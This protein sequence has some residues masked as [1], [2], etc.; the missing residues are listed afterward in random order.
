[1]HKETSCSEEKFV[2]CREENKKR[3]GS[4]FEYTNK[5]RKGGGGRFVE[6]REDF[7]RKKCRKT[8]SSGE[9][10]IK[11]WRSL[12]TLKVGGNEIPERTFH[13]YGIL[14][15]KDR[16]GTIE[17]QVQAENRNKVMRE[18][19]PA[20]A[21]KHDSA[22]TPIQKRNKMY[23]T[24]LIVTSGRVVVCVGTRELGGVSAMS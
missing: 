20:W 1:M 4:K 23:K 10:R 3:E 9:N 15:A 24:L 18:A 19:A 17:K 12:G 22:I 7:E 14:C 5:K 8:G 11:P 21:K 6:I 13:N 2:R 16:E